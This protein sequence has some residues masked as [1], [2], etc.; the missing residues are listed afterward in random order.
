MKELVLHL[1]KASKRK[2]KDYF[3]EKPHF[4]KP[5]LDDDD[6]EDMLCDM[7]EPSLDKVSSEQV[8]QSESL[9][10]SQEKRK[11]ESEDDENEEF[12]SKVYLK[13]HALYKEL[14]GINVSVENSSTLEV[15]KD[16]LRNKVCKREHI[17]QLKSQYQY[18][19]LSDQMLNIFDKARKYVSD[20]YSN[21]KEGTNPPPVYDV[22]SK[23]IKESFAEQTAAGEQLTEDEQ[24]LLAKDLENFI[25]STS[26]NPMYQSFVPPTPPKET[27]QKQ[28]LNPADLFE[29]T[30]KPNYPESIDP[31]VPQPS[32]KRKEESK[33]EEVPE[34]QF[35]KEKLISIKKDSLTMPK[36]VP[37]LVQHSQSEKIDDPLKL[38]SELQ[39]DEEEVESETKTKE[40]LSFF[41][42]I[43]NFLFKG[44]DTKQKEAKISL[45][46]DEFDTPVKK[47]PDEPILQPLA[48]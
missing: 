4:D 39:S 10:K 29:E 41:G 42:K 16:F 24:Y 20:S 34:D 12:H 2:H 35:I 37:N 19:S 48:K 44:K 43:K 11:H 17:K 47:I 22:I 21:V 15:I 30:P 27:E 23:L 40:K 6:D 5:K 45:S 25:T 32:M 36:E 31:Q 18:G 3:E 7:P 26:S 8:S 33:K 1:N 46:D 28:P 38:I 13:R 14:K 9:V